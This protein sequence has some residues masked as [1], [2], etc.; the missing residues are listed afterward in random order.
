MRRVYSDERL[1]PALSSEQYNGK[2]VVEIVFGTEAP[3]TDGG[4]RSIAVLEAAAEATR[5]LHQPIDNASHNIQME[6]IV[7]EAGND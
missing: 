2:T 5:N 6:P 3:D 4:T 1:L 7:S